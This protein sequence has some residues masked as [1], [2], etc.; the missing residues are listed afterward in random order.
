MAANK[1]RKKTYKKG[2]KLFHNETKAQIMFGNW[3]DK[4]TAT[5]LNLKT[6]LPFKLSRDELDD[7][8]TSYASL[9]RKYR[10]KRRYE[11]W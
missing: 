6:K 2:M 11:A 3:I 10:E 7:Q 4:N 9:D 1:A 5:C 8:Y